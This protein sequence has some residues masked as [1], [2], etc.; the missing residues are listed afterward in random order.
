MQAFGKYE[1]DDTASTMKARD[2]KDATDLVIHPLL[3]AHGTQDPLTM[4]DCAF[5]LGRN[6][7]QENAVCI[8]GEVT[9]TLKADGFDG[10]ED[11]TGSGQPIVAIPIHDQATRF[12]G[13]R[14]KNQDGKGNGLGIGREGDPML[15]LTAG[16]RH[17]VAYPLDLRNAGRDPDKR[18]AVNRQ[19]LGVGTESDPSPTVTTA[20]VPGVATFKPG[21]SA[22]ARGVGYAEE[23]APTLEGG[24]GG[25]NKPAL[26]QFAEMAVR[27][28]TPTEC[29]RLQ[30][31]PDNWTK[32]P[33]RKAHR[34]Y[35]TQPREGFEYVEIDGECWQL[36][37]DGPRYKACGN[38]FTTLVVRWIGNRIERQIV[39]A[40]MPDLFG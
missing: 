36:M 35:L 33:Y 27:R 18:D 10:S 2:Y 31:F 12:A 17:A 14:G 23:V 6:N 11:G 25:N 9:H 22:A 3:V 8:T 24:G 28:L 34:K 16:D 13:K 5:P 37:P 26:F 39:R 29:E 1:M 40:M 4:E 21:Q 38:S 15:T 7:G 30:G 32:V 19:G 20:F